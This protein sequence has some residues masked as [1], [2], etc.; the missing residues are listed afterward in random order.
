MQGIYRHNQ[1]HVMYSL[2]FFNNVYNQSKVKK[3]ASRSSIGTRR[4]MKEEQAPIVWRPGNAIHQI[5]Q[6]PVN[7]CQQNKPRYPLDSDLSGG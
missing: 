6:Y 2:E 3:S 1:T 4:W 5:N 7:K